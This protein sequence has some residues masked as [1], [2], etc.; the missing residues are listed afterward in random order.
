MTWCTLIACPPNL[1]HA[2]G[3]TFRHG[4][5]VRC[6]TTGETFFTDYGKL[7]RYPSSHVYDSYGNPP[8][9]YT[10]YGSCTKVLACPMGD[11]MPFKEGA[12]SAR[13]AVLLP[14]ANIAV[15]FALQLL[16]LPAKQ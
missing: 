16:D 6:A 15:A 3:C 7:R 13:C 11:P 12:A 14:A 5:V 4:T 1:P 9:E 10:D 2:A 8:V